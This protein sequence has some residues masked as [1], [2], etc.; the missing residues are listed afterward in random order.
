VIAVCLSVHGRITEVRGE[1]LDAVAVVAVGATTREVSLAMVP[2]ATVGDW[3][4]FHSGYALRVIGEEE[5]AR[6]SEVVG[7][8]E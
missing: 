7:E 8:L 2:E 3:V 1:G 6:L 4:V 5:A